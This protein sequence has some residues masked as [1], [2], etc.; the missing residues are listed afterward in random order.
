MSGK[1][2]YH[3]RWGKWVSDRQVTKMKMHAADVYEGK[4][5]M[6]PQPTINV[7]VAARIRTMTN[8]EFLAYFGYA[9]MRREKKRKARDEKE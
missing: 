4:V 6:S 1:I 9:N 3:L 2:E 7:R 5:K 8:S